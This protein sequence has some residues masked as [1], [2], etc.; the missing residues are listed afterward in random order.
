M[1][2]A[3]WM[4][5]RRY[6]ARLAVFSASVI[7]FGAIVLSVMATKPATTL[8]R[9]A[10]AWAHAHAVPWLTDVMLGVGYLGGPS[11][12]G[13]YA[14]LLVWYF[15]WRRRFGTALAVAA[16]A[17]GGMLL[18]V[19]VKHAFERA[20]PAIEDPVIVLTT[21]SFP[22]GHAAASTIFAGLLCVLALRSGRGQAERALAVVLAT[23][24][25]GIVCSSR[26]YLGLHYVSDVLAGVAEGVAW[27]ALSTLLLER[28]GN[29][30]VQKPP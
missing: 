3:D 12:T 27:L 14:F 19:V 5:P 9:A 7:L 24:W 1:L 29:A 10:M 28:F 17:F 26:V 23:I 20:R 15:L 8:D 22:S 4:E 6:G 18:N 25:V 30:P 11:V 16:I 2:S 21:Y 13:V